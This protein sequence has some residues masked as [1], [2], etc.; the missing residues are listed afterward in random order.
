MPCSLGTELEPLQS[1]HIKGTLNLSS[2]D[3]TLKFFFYLFLGV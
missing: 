1:C 3:I 2:N